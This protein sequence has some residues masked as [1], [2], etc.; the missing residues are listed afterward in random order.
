MTASIV[1][2]NALCSVGRGPEQI[3]ASVRS[4]I[5]RVENSRVLDR[6]FETIRMGLVN[7][8]ALAPLP[9]EVDALPL[10]PRA[11]RMLQ[12]GAPTLQALGASIGEGPMQLFLGVPEVDARR[13]PWITSFAL[14]LA[15]CAAVKLDTP[16]CRVIPAGR[17]AGLIAL[18]LALAALAANPSRRVVVGGVDTFFDFNLLA[19]LD[20]EGRVLGNRVMDGFIPGEGAAFFVLSAQLDGAPLPGGRAVRVLGTATT[21]DPGH[22]YGSEPARG[23][24]LSIALDALREK[25][26]SF[27]APIGTTFAGF[28][29][30]SFDAKLWGIASLRHRELFAP[31]M[32]MQ[33]PADC[34]GDTGAAS[35]ALLTVLAAAALTRGERVGPALVWAASD[36]ES[37]RLRID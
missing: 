18:D 36:R 15:E 19:R 17:A 7:E 20:R 5:A 32:R 12:L 3:W 34:M 11:R 21:R 35:G 29:G 9:P 23:E 33:H 8:D 37:A 22:R 30:E 13:E 16:N 31:A 25:V 27:P 2:C 10:P 28:N 26:G 4:G 6:E 24:G 14:H 1:D